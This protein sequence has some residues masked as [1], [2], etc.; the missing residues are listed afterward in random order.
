MLEI[1]VRAIG[2]KLREMEP[3]LDYTDEELRKKERVNLIDRT[4]KF[5]VVIC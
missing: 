2:E 5:E 3:D 1:L 4:T